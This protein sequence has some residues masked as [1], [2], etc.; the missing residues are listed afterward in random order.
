M[1]QHELVVNTTKADV[2]DASLKTTCECDLKYVMLNIA[3]I[4]KIS[5]YVGTYIPTFSL[6]VYLQWI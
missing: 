6:K 5:R 4:Q 1:S 2:N 3:Y